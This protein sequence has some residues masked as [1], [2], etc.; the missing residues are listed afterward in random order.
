[1]V[2]AEP[3][4]QVAREHVLEARRGLGL[5]CQ[6]LG[7]EVGSYVSTHCLLPVPPS[8]DEGG[9]QRHSRQG[10]GGNRAAD[11]RDRYKL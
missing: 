7:E 6:A 11:R 9:G 8:D 10:G 4:G 3:P 2:D 1:M 5:G